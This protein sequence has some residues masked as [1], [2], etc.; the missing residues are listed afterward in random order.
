[1][2]TR[3][4]TG[5]MYVMPREMHHIITI[6]FD[7]TKPE[8]RKRAL[9]CIRVMVDEAAKDGYGEYRTHLALYDQVAA[10]YN[11]NDGALMKLHNTLKDALDPNGI[12]QPGRCGVWPKS[13]RNQGWELTKDT[14]VP[15]L[16]SQI[17][18]I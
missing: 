16:A 17:A 18:K 8:E 7:R 9:E 2:L 6:L 14:V 3:L 1:M 10:T 15:K 13:Y 11:W 5:T 4:A 12:L